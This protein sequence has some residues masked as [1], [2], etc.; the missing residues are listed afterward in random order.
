[1]FALLTSGDKPNFTDQRTARMGLGPA[2]DQPRHTWKGGHL[3]ELE[4]TT[5]L[6][7]VLVF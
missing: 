3:F 4:A 1:V 7:P 2:C 5:S 6:L